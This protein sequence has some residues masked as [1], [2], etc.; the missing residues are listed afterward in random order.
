MSESGSQVFVSDGEQK[1]SDRKCTH[2]SNIVIPDHI[3]VRLNILLSDG[4]VRGEGDKCDLIFLSKAI[5]KW[6]YSCGDNPRF[7][8]NYS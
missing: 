5:R 2:G 4:E 7:Q 3:S 8:L 1:T 6:K